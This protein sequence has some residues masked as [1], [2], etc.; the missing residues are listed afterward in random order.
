MFATLC[1]MEWNAQ[2]PKFWESML[3]YHLPKRKTV[4]FFGLVGWPVTDVLVLCSL[5]WCVSAALFVLSAFPRGL[6]RFSCLRGLHI[7]P[8]P[9]LY[10]VIPTLHNMN[11]WFCSDWWQCWKTHF[12]SIS[13]SIFSFFA[14]RN[15]YCHGTARAGGCRLLPSATHA[16]AAAPTGTCHNFSPLCNE[17]RSQTIYLQHMIYAYNTCLLLVHQT[18]LNIKI[19]VVATNI[20]LHI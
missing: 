2:A 10:C 11:K 6:G 19:D 12:W 18:N 1:E 20:W 16:T 8:R 9:L 4:G 14:S 7:L 5:C 17:S 15:P 13:S 3:G